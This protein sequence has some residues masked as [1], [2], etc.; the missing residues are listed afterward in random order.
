MAK[1]VLPGIILV[2]VSCQAFAFDFKPNDALGEAL[3]KTKY[4]AMPNNAGGENILE[5]SCIF[6]DTFSLSHSEKVKDA[7]DRAGVVADFVGKYGPPDVRSEA[8]P[9]RTTLEY[10]IEYKEN[11]YNIKAIVGCEQQTTELQ[12]M[13]E[14]KKEKHMKMPGPPR[15]PG[16]L[17]HF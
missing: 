2:L 4:M 14:C 8:D 16:I 3:R 13:V 6:K 1:W 11:Q 17:P 7:C 9:K 12:Y 10:N 15:R 5:N